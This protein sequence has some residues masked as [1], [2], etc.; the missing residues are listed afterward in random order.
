[1]ENDNIQ[2]WN[3]LIKIKDNHKDSSVKHHASLLLDQYNTAGGS[4]TMKQECL[5]FILEH[6]EY[7]VTY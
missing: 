5:R 7:I 1:M 6:P 3:S 2:I 4:T